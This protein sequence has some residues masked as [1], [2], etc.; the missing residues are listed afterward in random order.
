[1]N[2]KKLIANHYLNMTPMFKTRNC[3]LVLIFVLLLNLLT[4]CM[5]ITVR[6]ISTIIVSVLVIALAIVLAIKFKNNPTIVNYLITTA[7]MINSVVTLLGFGV[8]FDDIYSNPFILMACIF[9]SLICSILIIRNIERRVKKNT[10]KEGKISPAVSAISSGAVVAFL[11]LTRKIRRNMNLGFLYFPVVILLS[12]MAFVVLLFTAKIIYYYTKS[13]R[14]D[15][16]N[17]Y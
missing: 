1:M 8:V 4:L 6:F 7:V 12:L 9:V 16:C 11:L 17:N 2:E 3:I 5:G 15:R 10:F 14:T 13:N